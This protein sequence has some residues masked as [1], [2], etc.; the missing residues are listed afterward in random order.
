MSDHI[1]DKRILK[2]L[3]HYGIKSSIVLAIDR[4]KPFTDDTKVLEKEK[5]IVDIGKNIK[6]SNCIDTGIFLCSSKILYQR[7]NKKW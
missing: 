2:E 1:F 5:R 4:R 6:K 3:I 7:I